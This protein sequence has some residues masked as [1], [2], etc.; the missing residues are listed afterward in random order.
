MDLNQSRS[1]P[2]QTV[3]T[4]HPSSEALK[5]KSQPSKANA[6]QARAG[7]YSPNSNRPWQLHPSRPSHTENG[8]QFSGDGAGFSAR[9]DERAVGRATPCAPPT[10]STGFSARAGERAFG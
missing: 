4:P 3:S 5:P 7:I 10:G 2:P 1:D 8:S 6:G 9:T